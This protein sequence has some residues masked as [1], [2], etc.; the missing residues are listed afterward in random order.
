MAIIESIPSRAEQLAA[1]QSLSA[2]AA[3]VL[4]SGADLFDAHRFWEAHEEWEEIW[5][6]E[7]RPIRSFYQGLIQIAAGYHHWTVTHRPNG[8]QRLLEAGIVKLSWYSPDYLGVDVDGVVADARRMRALAAG[9]DGGW[10][11]KFSL[12]EL[13]SFRWLPAGHRPA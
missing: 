11:G 6:R 2:D 13:P 5:Q 10:L 7:H 3:A 9:R 12:A 1:A 8:V 4:R